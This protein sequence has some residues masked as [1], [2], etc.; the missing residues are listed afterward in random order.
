M[1]DPLGA[2]W[3]I[4]VVGVVT[5]GISL[6][7]T[8]FIA[9]RKTW[10]RAKA[11]DRHKH[12]RKVLEALENP[13][14]FLSALRIGTDF[15][16]ILAG[17]VGSM[18]IIGSLKGWFTPELGAS[19]WGRYLAG[20]ILTTA[21]TMLMLILGDIIPKQ[22]ALLAPERITAV[23]LPYCKA[24]ALVCTPF[25]FLATRL[26]GLIRTCLR[27]DTTPAIGMTED[28]LRIALREG[29]KSGI[30]EQAERTMVEGVFYLGDRPV[31]TF[32]THRSDITWLDKRADRELV[33]QTA[34]EY[35]DQRYFPVA[36]GTLDAVTGVV[37]VQD[38]L[39]ALLQG[40]WSGLSSIM[41]RPSFVPETL[42][43]LKAFVAFKQ[44]HT[45][46]LLV[47]DEYGGFAGVLSSQALM[48]EIVGHLATP[49]LATTA[50]L[51]QEDG[52]YLV[53]GSVNIDD[54]AESLGF[55]HVLGE[56]QEYHTL[57]GF[58]L[59][60][61]EEI[62]RTGATFGY[63]GYRFTIAAMEGNR[64]HKVLIHPPGG[65][66]PATGTGD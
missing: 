40:P 23:A 41:K 36:E 26:G 27:I 42:S 46:F 37:S 4:L 48:E 60:L 39:L 20:V 19:P 12:D 15:L 38:I 1:E 61:A 28:E 35:R 49:A 30:V 11:E 10:L 18:G 22:L 44:G 24:L 64:I 45:D 62:P 29:E 33:R 56:H 17:V 55:D 13:L 65:L 58:I 9:S 16:R 43:A 52:T 6:V 3:F 7:E 31:G 8:A 63:G 53:E 50:M 2:I 57:A 47:M 66:R 21:I 5:G 25:S 59:S 14:L 54:V 51:L 34:L 32:M